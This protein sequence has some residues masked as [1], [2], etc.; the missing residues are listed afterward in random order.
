MRNENGLEVDREALDK[1]LTNADLITIGF[2]LFPE[3]LLIDTRTN[4][5]DGQ[6][7]AMVE[8]VA[9]VQERYLW[10]GKHRSS[11]GPPEGFAFFIW[12]H[13]V[14][15]LLERDAL[16]VLKERLDP[17]AREALEEALV[18]AAELERVAMMEAVRG[19]ERWPAMWEKPAA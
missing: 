15:G 7:A 5:V 14:R 8:P 9:S 10:L 16:K 1:L 13:T 18:V 11:F 6:F 2:T 17:P 3:R 12:P 19:S 4:D